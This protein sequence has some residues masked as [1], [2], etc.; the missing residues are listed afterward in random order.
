MVM[1]N[2]ITLHPWYR[3]SSFSIAMMMTRRRLEMVFPIAMFCSFWSIRILLYFPLF[4]V[5]RPLSQA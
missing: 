5:L 3:K 2:R 1:I 4:S